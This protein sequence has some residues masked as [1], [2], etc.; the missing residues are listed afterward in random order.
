MWTRARYVSLLLLLSAEPLLAGPAASGPVQPG[1]L[2]AICMEAN[3]HAKATDGKISCGA[4]NVP[5]Y[6]NGARSKGSGNFALEFQSHPEDGHYEFGIDI[7]CQASQSDFVTKTVTITATTTIQPV[8]MTM[9][10]DPSISTVTV[11]STTDCADSRITPHPSPT[12]SPDPTKFCATGSPY[13]WN[14][15][16][17][18]KSGADCAD[19]YRM[20]GCHCRHLFRG[21]IRRPRCNDIGTIRCTSCQ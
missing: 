19:G 8:T 9:T 21:D 13:C 14:E 10:E 18:Y 2:F 20:E 15:R 6:Y 7:R 3:T 4:G 1:D 16:E 12:P 11:I 5:A 17:Q